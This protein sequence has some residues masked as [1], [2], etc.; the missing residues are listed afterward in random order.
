MKIT[1]ISVK[2]PVA[3]YMFFAGIIL[4]GLLAI[5]RLPRDLFPDI[6]Y[7]TLT[8]VTVYPGASAEQVEKEVT[9]P[10]EVILA[11]T[12]NIKNIQ[13]FSKDNVSTISLQ[14]DWGSDITEAAANARDLIELVKYQLPS[15]AQRPIIMKIN[16]SVMPVV[17]L[18]LQTTNTNVDISDLIEK[19][20]SPRLQHIDGV[21][22]VISI[23]Q[24]ETEIA[25]EIDPLKAEKYGLT[26]DYIANLIKSFNLN[27]PAGSLKTGVWDL[28]V[29]VHGSVPSIEAIYHLPITTYLG[30]VI[31]L[32][33]I[34]IVKKQY[35]QKDEIARTHQE[36][37][38]A[39]MVQ[40]QSQANAL[41]VYEAVKKEI[42][43]LQLPPETNIY[44]VFNTT[45]IIKGSINNITETLLWGGLCVIIV[46]W[47]FLR[48]WRSSLII[49]LAIPFSLLI[50]LITMMVAGFTIN[51]FTL[52]SMVVAIGMIID[53][54]I[55]VVENITKYIDRGIRKKEASIFATGEMGQAIT[56]STFTTIAVFFPLIFAG[57]IVGMF[58]QQFAIIGAT[59]ML[60]SLLIALTL[61]P[62]AS[63]QLFIEK[64]KQK[65]R[66]KIYEKTESW[67][68]KLEDNYGKL[69]NW[70]LHNKGIIIII[71]VAFILLAFILGKWFI[72]TD[73]IPNV[74]G[75][76]LIT[77]I[78][79]P[80]GYS[81]EETEKVAAKVEKFIEDNVPE[82]LY[83]FTV[84]GQTDQGLLSSV[85]F[86]ENKNL[87]TIVYHLVPPNKRKRSAEEIA[88]MIVIELK[89]IP[90]IEQFNVV[91]GSIL[92][93]A[94]LGSGS[95][96]EIV[97]TGTDLETLRKYAKIVEDSL[98]NIP[99]L[100]NIQN[101]IVNTKPEFQV[102]LDKDRMANLNINPA[103][104]AMQV[105]Q[106]L[107]GI[108]AGK[109]EQ[110]GKE[111]PINIKYMRDE[112]KSVNDVLNI[113]ISSLLGS[114][115][116]LREVA[117]VQ[118]NNGYI[119]IMHDNQQRVA[120][121]GAD[122]NTNVD[123][124]TV[125][126]EIQKIISSIDTYDEVIIK[127]KGQAEEQAKSFKDLGLI[128]VISV[129]L[130]YM[131]MAAQ[132]GNLLQ[133]FIIFLSS[134]FA[135]VGSIIA[136]YLTGT[137][138]NLIS[139]VA[140]ILLMGVVV[141]NGIVLVD[142]TNMLIKRGYSLNDAIIAAGISRLRPV[143][144]TT[145][146]TIMGIL[147][148]A[149]NRGLL[150][151]IW[152]PFGITTIGGLFFATLITLIWIPLLYSL[153][154]SHFEHK[155]SLYI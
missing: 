70:S 144:M 116:P 56:A 31:R 50:A 60:G 89:K 126:K 42:A 81:V 91:G 106:S 23:A 152:S 38:T 54:N 41:Q 149:I 49:S 11:S 51:V 29:T 80:D 73:Y 17:I 16:S 115:Y 102:T 34:A 76:D 30:Q 65:K 142:Y 136:F 85:G 63:S 131:I 103:I 95:P 117:E 82:I 146:T 132:F 35:K 67:Y 137:T 26:I 138:L 4:F 5:F 66:L 147:P 47:L 78:Q 13:S 46:V 129:L 101:N 28:N 98:K 121:V 100:K 40:K 74:D 69:I 18:G 150:H 3:I 58:F 12:E 32:K 111:I 155:K 128:L 118:L 77:V 141:N 134:P 8:V 39:L 37:G 112:L 96:V 44:E 140:I 25:V 79:M 52:M 133:P 125:T 10:L 86:K 61:T 64:S 72:G 7:P 27:V 9:N 94:L 48:A 108:E 6:E 124:G 59:T 84:A 107:Y 153:F 19:V 75:G 71:M 21:G 99:F 62:T 145:F 1:D 24:P 57:G 87:A 119:E 45:E 2:N 92:A 20:I 88:D 143:L 43:C 122:I 109:Y 130:V 110:Q 113:R 14:F 53:N 36:R 154:Y 123:L 151:E 114:S 22:T 55:V 135:V 90:E 127:Q 83:G 120:V 68:L 148:M 33:D 104:A 93:S 97:I 105:R 15:E 139:F